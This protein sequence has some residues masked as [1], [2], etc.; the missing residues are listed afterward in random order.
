MSLRIAFVGFRHGH[1][2]GLYTV[3][4]ERDDLEVVAACEEDAETRAT[5]A[6]VGIEV[7]HDSYEA[8][9]N[10][11]PC[12]IVACGDYFGVR[13]ERV[14]RALEHGK[15]VLC[16]KPLCIR[17][18]ELERI[19]ELAR[20]N[21][22]SVGCMLDLIDKPVMV[23]L[24]ELIRRG[25][26]GEVLSMTVLGQHPLNYGSRPMWYFEEGKHGGTINDIG[27]HAIDALPWLSGHAIAEITAARG[28]NG[29]IKEHPHFGDGAHLMLKLANG[30]GVIADFS[31]FA[32]DAPGFA[33]PTYWRF[34]VAGSEGTVE[35]GINLD[36]AT[37]WP[38]DN[39]GARE[40]EL[41]DGRPN[42]YLD[43]FLADI[44]GMP[45]PEGLDTT[46]VIHSA[47]VSLLAQQAANSA[48]APL[49]LAG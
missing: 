39:S 25:D 23:T 19:E 20:E 29:R 22:L 4:Q 35:A 48:R 8:M 38:N 14:I 34:T 7:T 10:E 6:D 40:I 45:P 37:L 15:H 24:R 28:W 2:N 9:L 26:L 36:K 42:G 11:A 18:D 17:L 12:D 33:M 13:G 16:D 47:R 3:A 43:D 46:R 44:G 31:Y 27:I 49:V 5:L 41:M 32:P 21:K 1:I 30:C